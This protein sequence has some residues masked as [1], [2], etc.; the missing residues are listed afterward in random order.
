MPESKPDASSKPGTPKDA[1]MPST[2]INSAKVR[3]LEA[4]AQKCQTAEEAA[5]LYRIFMVAPETTEDEREQA[6]A[7]LE[8]WEQA[9][10]DQLVRVGPKWMPKVDADALLKEADDLVREAN[11]LLNVDNFA[12]ANSKLEKA[13]KVYPDHLESVFLLALGALINRDYKAAEVKFN[14]CLSRAPDNAAL[15]NNVGYCEL[16]MKR[17]PLAVKH[18][19]HAAEVDLENEK[20]A[21]NLGQF[22]SDVNLKRLPMTDKRALADATEAYQKMIAKDPGNR[23]NP[24]KGYV[25]SRLLR[26]RPGDS[27]GETSRAVGNGAGF[28]IAEHFILT[29]RHV[30]EDADSLVIQDPMKPNG[31]PLA[32]SVVAKSKDLD[33]AIVECRQLNAPAA[34]LNATPVGRGTEVMALGYPIASIVGNGLKATRGIITGLP[35]EATEKMLILDVQV[36]PGNS[37]GPL[38]DRSGRVV[39]VVAAKTFN[40]AFV[41]SYGLAIPIADA[42][43]FINQTIKDYSPPKAENR[44]L[45]WTDVD[46]AISP[47]TVMIV[48]QKKR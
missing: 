39:G 3:A 25:M 41:Q 16:Q 33:L 10:A 17:Y 22:I 18:W 15:L 7:R 4:N 45:E 9:A 28:V 31:L 30:V 27:T 32:A 29:N 46:A 36:N 38:C 24:S 42:L 21:Q 8:Y 37:G 23:A 5:V 44:S 14:Q 13:A 19:L 47:S 6:G 35:S 1:A 43:P 26:S 20:V 11:E 40:A 12:A 48:I 34:P 2:P